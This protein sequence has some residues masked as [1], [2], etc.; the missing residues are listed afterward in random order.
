MLADGGEAGVGGW[1][2]ALAFGET[3]LGEVSVNA[4][5]A[6]LSTVTRDVGAAVQVIGTCGEW[7]GRQGPPGPQEG[8]CHTCAHR[9]GVAALGTQTVH[10]PGPELGGLQE[11]LG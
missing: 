11:G 6:A 8:L 4:A 2:G 5:T 3:V 10:L 9:R 1:T 7:L